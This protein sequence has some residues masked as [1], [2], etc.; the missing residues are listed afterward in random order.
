MGEEESKYEERIKLLKPY[1]VNMDMMK[2]TK[3]NDAIFLHC[4][5]AFH[6]LETKVGKEIFEKQWSE[7]AG[8]ER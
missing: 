6:D 4:L 2:K 7:I 3:N 5:P 8:S 1:Q